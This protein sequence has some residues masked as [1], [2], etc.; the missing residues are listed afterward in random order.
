MPSKLLRKAITL[1]CS[2]FTNSYRILILNNWIWTSLSL[3]KWLHDGIPH[4]KAQI[5]VSGWVFFIINLHILFI[6][7]LIAQLGFNCTPTW[8]EWGTMISLKCVDSS[9]LCWLGT[10]MT[11]ASLALF[12]GVG[13]LKCQAFQSETWV[14]G[15]N[16][17]L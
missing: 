2:V 1:R 12:L 6:D 11:L 17:I 13:C 14:D 4:L 8:A 15:L 9:Y 3:I 7:H 10:K 16:I 5:L